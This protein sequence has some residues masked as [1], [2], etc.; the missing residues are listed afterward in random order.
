MDIPGHL[1][2]GPF[3]Y[4]VELHDGYWNKDDERV[5]GEVDERTCTINLDI[6]ASQEIVKDAIVH[7]IIHAILMMYSR[8]D[9][10]LV[11]ILSPMVLQ[12]IRDNPQLVAFLTI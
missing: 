7:E 2:I 4:N 9:E 5:Y 10:E 8:D 3:L 11:R 6:D 1:R 12:V